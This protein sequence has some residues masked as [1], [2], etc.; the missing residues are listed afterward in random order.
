RFGRRFLCQL[1]RTLR[2]SLFPYTTLFRSEVLVE[3]LD[4]DDL[5]ALGVRRELQDPARADQAGDRQ[6]RPVRLGAPLVEGED[7]LVAAAVAQALLGDLPE[8]LVVA[9]LRRP[10]PVDLR[11]PGPLQWLRGGAVGARVRCVALRH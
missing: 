9:P 10:H 4:G 1:R 11:R 6:P 8:A 5:R 2:S 7:L 3:L